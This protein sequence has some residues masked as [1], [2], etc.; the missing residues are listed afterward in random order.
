MN[1][2]LKGAILIIIS[3]F[4]F[5]LIGTFVRAINIS[6]ERML[7]FVSLFA[8]LFLLIYFAFAKKLKKLIIKKGR[9]LL[10]FSGILL[11]LNTFSYFKAYTLTTFSNTVLIHYLAPII[12]A[13]LVP[14]FFKEK[15]ERITIISLVISLFG[16]Y[17]ITSPNLALGSR[18][19]TGMFFAFLSA[20][21]YGLLIIVNKKLVENL[22][23]GAILFY[24]SLIPALIL[25]PFIGLDFSL[26]LMPFSLLV[27]YTLLVSI[28]P[29]FLY[30]AGIKRVEA[31]H[32][33][34]IGY[35][36][37][38]FVVLLGFLLFKEIP[39]IT[40]F[41]GGL[42]ILFGGYLVIRAEAK[43]K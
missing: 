6:P 39:K 1:K 28:L 14:I 34:I 25:L 43:R 21:G 15:L 23:L 29:G 37:V 2:H 12:A 19:L 17:L 5:S 31:Q 13:L 35:A 32:V 41:I 11:I 40:T 24:Q 26:T 9:L 4:L 18:H 20:I 42:L 16:L 38:I 10:F 30:L 36:E 7:F 8:A 22:N 27:A 3:M 33:G